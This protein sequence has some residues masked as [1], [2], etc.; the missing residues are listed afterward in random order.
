MQVSLQE[1]RSKFGILYSELVKIDEDEDQPSYNLTLLQNQIKFEGQAAFSILLRE[2]IISLLSYSKETI[3][4]QK[5]LLFLRVNIIQAYDNTIFLIDEF[6][7]ILNDYSSNI[8]FFWETIL[9]A[10]IILF[11]A[12]FIINLRNWYSFE[13]RHKY[14]I[15]IISRIN[16]DQA[17]K[18]VEIK[19]QQIQNSETEKQQ[20]NMNQSYYTCKSPLRLMQSTINQSYQNLRSR[21]SQFLYEKIQNKSLDIIIKLGIA[22]FLYITLVAFVTFGYFQIQLSESQHRPIENLIKTYVKFEVQLGYLLSF[23]TILKGQHL[24][25]EQFSKINDPEIGDIKNYFQE[26]KVPI[27]FQNISQVYQKKLESIFSSIILSDYIDDNDKSELYDLYKGDF[28][29]YLNDILPFCNITIP[30]NQFE[31]I[32]GQF[33][34][35]ENNSEVLRKGITGFISNLDSLFKNDFEIEISQGIY[36]KNNSN[37]I[38]YYK[39]YNNLVVQYFFNISQGFQLFYDKI[40][41]V[42]QDLIKQKKNNLL[43]YFYT[44]GLTFLFIYF[45]TTTIHIICAQRRY[46]NCILGLVTLTEDLLNDKT[47]L[48]LLKRLSK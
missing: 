21:D 32:Y 38:Y 29:Y 11:S 42:S 47:N 10:Q 34:P 12:P 40:D 2:T 22:L 33:Y 18:L 16:E 17:S 36:Q 46:K 43:V 4:F 15:Q 41:I 37:D 6:T 35:Y 31:N 1:L 25:Q 14:L 7:Q 5:S 27:Y 19:Q 3:Q 44:F 45:V 13:K 9:I 26:D 28:C 39:E 48:N 8:L 30:L 24:F 23:A 20:T